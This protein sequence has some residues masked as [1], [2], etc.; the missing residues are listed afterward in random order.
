MAG[1]SSDRRTLR[2][3]RA[4]Q[5][6]A[7]QVAA[8]VF[9]STMAAPNCCAKG[10]APLVDVRVVFG[11]AFRRVFTWLSV[12]FAAA[13]TSAAAAETCGVAIDVPAIARY[14][15]SFQVEST[16]TDASLLLGKPP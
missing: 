5:G 2:V 7:Q 8:A 6:T 15:P 1:Q 12:Q 16:L 11:V 9:G 14:P 4:E 3:L 13:M 10:P